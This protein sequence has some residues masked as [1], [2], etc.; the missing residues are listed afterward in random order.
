MLISRLILVAALAG[1]VALA[2]PSGASAVRPDA[3]RCEYRSNPLGIDE[4]APRLSWQVLAVK[5]RFARPR[6]ERL[7]RARRLHRS[8]SARGQGR[9]VGY[10]QGARAISAQVE[11]PRQAARLRVEAFWQ[12][13]RVGPAGQASDWSETGALV[14]GAV[15][16]RA[17]GKR[18][19]SA[20]TSCLLTRHP[21]SI[22]HH[23]KP[24]HWISGGRCEGACILR[25]VL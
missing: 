17:T 16:P 21:D 24:A 25:D 1:A 22:Y 7:P 11:Y 8:R 5:P 13:Q 18:S 15:S 9:P 2:A 23:L 12:V 19:G 10:G 20:P 14:H 4:T 3:L 6:A